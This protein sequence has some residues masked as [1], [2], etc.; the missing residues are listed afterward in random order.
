MRSD[1][2]LSTTGHHSQ[3]Q[4]DSPTIT[5]LELFCGIGG[6]AAALAHRAQIVAAVDQNRRALSVY[7]ANFAHP[8]CPCVV[9]SIPDRTWHGWS[10]DL[11]WMSPPCQPFTGRGIHRDLDDPR[12]RG[13]VAVFDRVAALRPRVVALE[14]VL[15][16]V[17]SRAHQLV[18]EVLDRAGYTTRETTVC[19][20]ELGLPNRRP[21]VYLLASRESLP[22]WPA[23]EGPAVA[24]NDLFDPRPSPALWCD[25]ELERQYAGAI[26]VVDAADSAACTACF[27]S[28]YGRSIVRSGSYLRTS[29][30]LRRFSPGEILRLLGF[31][32]SYRLPSEITT[33]AGW[34]MVGNSVSVRAVS[35]LLRPILDIA[36]TTSAGMGVSR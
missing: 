26:D 23:R 34:P 25:P 13:L 22:D 21:R 14:N 33:S 9:E 30:G 24:L 7:A 15:G 10:A 31:P 18:R 20:S 35:W 36:P 28:A 4:A 12:T 11:W 27:T 8:T 5:V 1:E 29:T 17:G 2:H 16:F 6:V 32:S 3:A 19:P